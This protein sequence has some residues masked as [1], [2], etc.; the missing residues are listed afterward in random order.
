MGIKKFI[1]SVKESLG[2]DEF[3]KSSKKKSIKKLLKRLNQKQDETKEL[4]KTKLGKKKRKIVEEEM[5]ILL[6]QIKKGD[7]ILK[8]LL[9]N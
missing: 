6:M 1:Q 7:K 2:L 5:E 8:K 3:K 4:L 9:E